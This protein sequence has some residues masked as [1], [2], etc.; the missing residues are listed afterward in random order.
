MRF[1]HSQNLQEISDLCFACMLAQPNVK[2]HKSC[3]AVAPNDGEC[4]NCY[5]RPMFCVDCMA[6]WFASRQDQD[7]KEKWLQQTCTCPM[8]RAKFCML[9]VCLI[10][11]RWAITKKDLN[12]DFSIKWNRFPYCVNKSWEEI[13]LALDCT[14]TCQFAICTHCDRSSSHTHSAYSWV[15]VNEPPRSG[16]TER[17]AGKGGMLKRWGN[18]LCSIDI[19]IF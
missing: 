9:D 6:K 7:E 13:S 11:G 17:L 1:F 3:P 8:C 5:C 16:G 4:T 10:D 18:T 15:S 2:L 12:L 19:F 14:C